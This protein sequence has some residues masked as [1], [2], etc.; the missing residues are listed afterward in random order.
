MLHKPFLARVVF[1]VLLFV[2]SPS[3]SEPVSS[4]SISSGI[5]TLPTTLSAQEPSYC[6][7]GVFDEKEFSLGS[8]EKLTEEGLVRPHAFHLGKVTLVGVG[9]GNSKVSALEKLARENSQTQSK[10]AEEKLRSTKYCTWYLNHPKKSPDPLRESAAK[11]FNQRDVKISPVE[12]TEDQA[13]SEFMDVF[14]NTVDEGSV[15]FLSC[16]QNEHYIALGCNEMMHRGPT[17]FGMLLA[18][19]GCTPEH[20]LEI[21]DQEWGLNGV[22]RKVRLAVIR[23]AFELGSAHKASRKKLAE[24]FSN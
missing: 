2:S 6:D 4:C 1:F 14:Q 22:K 19:S 24:L 17:V 7:P 18:F 13:V 20:A 5:A 3:F 12:L 21:T 15:N 16:A 11:A 10:S 8:F 23:K 9:V